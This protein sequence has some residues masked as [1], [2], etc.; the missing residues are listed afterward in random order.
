MGSLTTTRTERNRVTVLICMMISY[1]AVQSQTPNCHITAFPRLLGG[2]LGHT[3]FIS[4]EFNPISTGDIAIGGASFDSSLAPGALSTIPKPIVVYI[5]DGGPYLWKKYFVTSYY[6][7]PVL[8]F[9]PSSPT[10][11]LVAFSIDDN[12]SSCTPL[13]FVTLNPIDGE[14]LQSYSFKESNKC[15]N[16]R[17]KL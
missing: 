12:I 17:I 7:Y 14:I 3:M 1:I 15:M 5:Q 16:P 2:S 6:H 9:L 13:T 10:K 4:M 11:I 8:K